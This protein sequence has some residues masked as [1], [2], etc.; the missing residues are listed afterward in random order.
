MSATVVVLFV[1]LIFLVLFVYLA[2]RRG[3]ARADASQALTEIRSLDIDAFRNLIDPAEEEFLRSKLS[4]RAFRKIQRERAQAA[5]AYV[6]ALSH[7]S[8]QFARLGGAAQKSPDPAIAASGRQLANNA[9]YLR[10]R[11]LQATVSLTVSPAFPYLGRLPLRSLLD[12]YDRA[13]R[14]LQNHTGLERARSQ[15]I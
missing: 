11:A 12:Q 5:L 3:R 9:T 7:A 14:L 15:T 2:T 10:F 13:T 1:A 6:R 4:P 8:L